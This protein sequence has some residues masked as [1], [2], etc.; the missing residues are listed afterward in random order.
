[1]QKIAVSVFPYALLLLC[2]LAFGTLLQ[3]ALF[4]GFS[5]LLVVLTATL[6]FPQKIHLFFSFA[7]A[8]IPRYAGIQIS[9]ALP[10]IT[11]TRVLIVYY[12]AV[13]LVF[14]GD[15]LLGN[16]KKQRLNALNVSLLLFC[17]VHLL[18]LLTNFNSNAFKKFFAIMFENIVV[19]YFVYLNM[20]DDKMIR[21]CFDGMIAASG[22]IAL[23]AMVEFVTHANFFI[24]MGGIGSMSSYGGADRMANA[25][26][27]I[28]RLGYTRVY[29]TFSHP[30]ALAE[31]CLLMVF[32]AFHFYLA[33]KR[34]ARQ[35]YY[36]AI[37]CM[38]IVTVLLTLSRGPLLCLTCG[39]VALLFV[40]K[41]KRRVKMLATVGAAGFALLM[42]VLSGYAPSLLTEGVF[43]L[44]ASLFGVYVGQFGGNLAP[45][46]GRL[47]LFN[48]TMELIQGQELLGGG[49]AYFNS[50]RVYMFDYTVNAYQK[51]LVD[52]YDNFYLLRMLESGYIGL[53]SYLGAFGAILLT[54][55][56][57]LLRRARSLESAKT[58]VCGVFVA[59]GSYLV[60]L[61]TADE[62]STIKIF[63]VVAALCMAMCFKGNAEEAAGENAMM[64]PGGQAP[65]IPARDPFPA[66]TEGGM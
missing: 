16:L 57:F 59:M 65:E 20:K 36:G 9:T 30:I 49:L 39:M 41:K 12:L 32:P 25:G 28:Q 1:M 38:L 13:S 64:Q 19:F 37:T 51:Y 44:I 2:L 10:D 33:E 56:R 40:V 17:L 4:L 66:E 52:S 31:Y 60:S 11:L 8:L 5:V 47:N 61:V 18:S 35:I 15:T 14:N 26:K 29:V 62:L 34:A 54:A 55:L 24:Q 50:H 21:Q 27:S 46:E 6:L 63:W 23:F 3:P 42:F 48:I 43:S 45:I 22:V 58:L 53:L 7:L